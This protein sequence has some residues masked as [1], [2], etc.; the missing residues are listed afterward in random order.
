VIKSDSSV[1][2]ACGA[3]PK[4]PGPPYS[5]AGANTVW[6]C[7]P[8]SSGAPV[9]RNPVT[10]GCCSSIRKNGEV[11]LR[12]RPQIKMNLYWS[13]KGSNAS[14]GF[15]D[16]RLRLPS[17]PMRYRANRRWVCINGRLPLSSRICEA[18]TAGGIGWRRIWSAAS[19]HSEEWA[20]WPI[21]IWSNGSGIQ[22]NR[23][24]NQSS[25]TVHKYSYVLPIEGGRQ[26]LFCVG[27]PRAGR[28][29]RRA[30]PRWK[31]Q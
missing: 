10:S 9:L 2:W 3:K 28:A 15:F 17:A 31:G 23:R 25:N 22:V 21:W 20:H 8:S 27:T 24:S 19:N 29:N 13:G 11:P 7:W 5:F 18:S 12:W 14:N 4:R 30:R 26:H 6:R 1:R 16:K